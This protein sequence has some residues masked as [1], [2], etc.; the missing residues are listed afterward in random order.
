MP[1]GG[2]QIVGVTDASSVSAFAARWPDRSGDAIDAG[3]LIKDGSPVEMAL[4]AQRFTSRADERR[5]SR[6]EMKSKGRH[7]IDGPYHSSATAV[8]AS[9]GHH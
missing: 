4:R 1:I 9:T 2:G 8:M 7:G 5:P 3:P 6:R